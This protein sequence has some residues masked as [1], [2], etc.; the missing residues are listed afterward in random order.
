MLPFTTHNVLT[1]KDSPLGYLM[2]QCLRSYLNLDMWVSM[3][4]HTT[5][6]IKNGQKELLQFFKLINVRITFVVIKDLLI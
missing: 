3:E 2:L 6:T 4:V 1:E 5:D